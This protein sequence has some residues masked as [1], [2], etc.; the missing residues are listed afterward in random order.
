CQKTETTNL[1]QTK[2]PGFIFESGGLVQCLLG[3]SR[4]K[5]AGGFDESGVG[6]LWIRSGQECLG[7]G[8]AASFHGYHCSF[9]WDDA[10]GESFLVHGRKGHS[11]KH[12][13][14]VI[15]FVVV[16]TGF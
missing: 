3:P 9:E 15:K 2:T 5:V 7:I 6:Q 11:V 12:F 4:I 13:E 14:S 16:T 10:A 8:F 1:K